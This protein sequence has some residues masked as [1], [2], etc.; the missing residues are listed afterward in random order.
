MITNA[1]PWDNL[2][3]DMTGIDEVKRKFFGTLY[4]TY[5]FFSLYANVDNF[6]YTEN[7]IPVNER[8][9]IDRW[10]ISLLNSLI[11]EVGS[12]Y[13]DYDL[14]RA[15]RSVQDFVTENLSNWYVRLNRKRY[16]GGEYDK[17]KLSAY[18]TLYACLETVSQLMAPIAPFYSERL[19]KD[20]NSVTDKH[21]GDSVHLA[22]FPGYDEGLI[23]KA[24]EE[25]MDIAQKVS[26]MILGLRRK[27]S[28]KVRQPLARIMVPVPDKYFR[29]KFEAVKDLILAEV[30]VRNV[31]YID[32]TSSVLVKKIKPNFKALGPRYG[33]LMKEISK[34][35]NTLTPA[36]I[37]AFEK[38]GTHIAIVSGQKV[39]LT[40]ED[41]EIISED[42][43]GWQV[44]NEGKLTVALDVTVTDDLRY[45]GIAREFVNRIQNIRKENGYDV[46]DKITVLI[47]NHESLREAITRHGTYIASQT[48]AIAVE[49]T[50]DFSGM[51]ANEVEI[52][53]ITVRVVVKKN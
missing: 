14:T 36:E 18:Q 8:P 25:R 35:I 41:V 23:D 16:W 15:G 27:V 31:E 1:Q 44:A 46:T 13:S 19:F 38:N 37:T 45:E 6:R 34:V 3:F 30:N 9:E 49:L 12:S 33:K 24:L 28:I 20:L 22:L 48:L 11:K 29:D 7:E 21:H 43:P 4:N 40:T 32:D 51:K 10:I 5:S 52:D 26:S 42:I 39:D 2:K 17:D 47:E 50:T 53:E